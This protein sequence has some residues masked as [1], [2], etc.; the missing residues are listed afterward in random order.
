MR[1]P[2]RYTPHDN[3]MGYTIPDSL[4]A[5]EKHLKAKSIK[6]KTCSADS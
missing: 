1:L 5:F 2:W 4:F 6:Y 3:Y